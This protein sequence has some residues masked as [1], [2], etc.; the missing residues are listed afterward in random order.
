MRRRKL[1]I[2]I[3]ILVCLSAYAAV[4][5]IWW[6]NCPRNARSIG[7]RTVWIVECHSRNVPLDGLG[8][9]YLWYPAFWTL[10]HVFGYRAVGF[11]VGQEEDVVYWVRNPPA[12][13]L[14]MP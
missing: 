8:G 6:G 12:E 7:D 14:R 2:L 10:Q 11:A 1:Y 3:A 13:W 5:A 4:F 9:E